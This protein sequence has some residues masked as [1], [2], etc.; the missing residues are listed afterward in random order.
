MSNTK[1]RGLL[2]LAAT[3][4]APPALACS[5]VGP[6]PH[7]I[8]DAS[9]DTTPPATPTLLSLTIGRGRARGLTSSSCDDLGFLTLELH[10]EDDTSTADTI[11]LELTLINGTLPFDLPADP[12]RPQVSAGVVLNW[13]DGAT[14]AQEP[15]NAT[16]EVRA[17]DEAGNVSASP[18]TVEIIDPGRFGGGCATSPS[19]GA[20]A[21]VGLLALRRRG[22]R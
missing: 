12:V 1:T 7:A 18:L 13:I 22:A 19:T 14:A 2:A 6:Q 8:L 16:L 20:W 10:T 11:G 15:I 5:V 3:L 17:V 21:L 4:C 9:D